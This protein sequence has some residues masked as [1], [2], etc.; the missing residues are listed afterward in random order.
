MTVSDVCRLL[1]KNTL[2]IVSCVICLH[3][4][5][6]ERL[7]TEKHTFSFLQDNYFSLVIDIYIPSW[8]LKT[9]FY[10]Q[11]KK[12]IQQVYVSWSKSQTKWQLDRA[13]ASRTDAWS[14]KSILQIPL[15]PWQLLQILEWTAYHRFPCTPL[16]HMLCFYYYYLYFV[17]LVHRQNII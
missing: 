17:L 13:G 15:Q 5:R 10:F 7:H 6:A 3:E 4:S 1:Q 11:R 16:F 12:I 2:I 9:P 8:P 14:V